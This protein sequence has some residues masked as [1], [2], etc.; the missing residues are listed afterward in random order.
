MIETRRTASAEATSASGAILGKR[1]QNTP[2]LQWAIFVRQAKKPPGGQLPRA[3]SALNANLVQRL[4]PLEPPQ[5]GSGRAPL[6]AA[7]F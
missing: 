5:F 7:Y 6:I 4:G 3:S 2:R 1:S